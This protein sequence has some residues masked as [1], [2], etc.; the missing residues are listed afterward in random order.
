MKQKRHTTEEI[1]RLLREADQG[2]DPEAVCRKH[3]VLAA[4]FYRW[5]KKFGGMELKDARKYRQLERENAELKQML[6]D[7]LLEDPG[8]GGS[9]LKKW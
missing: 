2:K 7:S 9:K 3:N 6:A 5:M 1:I 4:S 8:L